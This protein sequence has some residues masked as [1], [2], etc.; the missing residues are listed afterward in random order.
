MRVLTLEIDSM[1]QVSERERHMILA[2]EAG[3]KG[4]P[5]GVLSH[6]YERRRTRS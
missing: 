2:Q 5:A 3:L 4:D 1:V 6:Y